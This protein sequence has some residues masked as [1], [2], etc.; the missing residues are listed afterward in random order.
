MS[1]LSEE[2][3]TFTPVKDQYWV[4]CYI[5]DITRIVGG[6]DTPGHHSEDRKI[7]NRLCHW[8]TDMIMEWGVGLLDPVDLRHLVNTIFKEPTDHVVHVSDEGMNK[9]IEVMSRSTQ[10]HILKIVLTVKEWVA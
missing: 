9:Y 2:I 3:S 7:C 6:P 8:V 5:N 4:G 10:R 1:I